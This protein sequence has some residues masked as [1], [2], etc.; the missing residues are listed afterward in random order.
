[1]AGVLTP[2]LQD[3]EERHGAIC[4]IHAS[5]FPA[6]WEQPPWNPPVL[7]EVLLTQ[8]FQ[9]DQQQNWERKECIL[10]RNNAPLGRGYASC[11]S[12][13]FHLVF[14]DH[15]PSPCASAL[16]SSGARECQSHTETESEQESERLRAGE[17]G[18]E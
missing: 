17:T 2:Y 16:S 14:P 15:R 7:L 10:P 12:S 11:P 13:P 3:R 9:N 5:L 6:A 18:R 8:P 1:M 4:L